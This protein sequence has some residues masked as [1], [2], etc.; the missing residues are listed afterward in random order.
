VADPVAPGLTKN[1]VDA[2]VCAGSTLT[3]TTSSGS[4]GTGTI[5]DQYQYS[6]DNGASWSGWSTS[7]PSFAAVTGTNLVQSRRTASGTGCDTSP[8]NTV[9]WTVVADPVAPGIT[10][11]PADA[12]VCS[13]QTLTVTTS[14]GSGG[15][16][17]TADEY[18]YS[19]DNGG[20]WSS[21]GESVPSFAAVVGI[22]KIQ[23]RRT[24]SGTGCDVSSI[25]EVSWTVVADPI[26][27]G[28]TKNPVDA[29]VCAG[30]TLTVSSIP[31]SGGTGTINDQY[32]YSTDNGS[33][34]SGWSTSVPSFAAVAGT[35]KIQSRRTATGTG[36]DIS[37]VNE[38]S[39]VVNAKQKIT[40]TFN[41]YNVS[42]NILLTGADITVDLYK[43][44]DA[45]HTSLIA[46]DVTDASGYYEL[47]A[48]CPD[49][50]YDIVASSTHTTDGA[51][52]TT[53]AAQANYWGPNPYSIEKVRFHAGDVAGQDLF[54]GGTD[55]GLI[56][57]N[58]VN[59]TDFEAP[60]WTYWRAG[61]AILH[62]PLVAEPEYTEYFP[63]VT[64]AVGSDIN[65]NMYGLATGDFNRSFN[66]SLTKAAS[67]TLLLVY[68]GNRQVGAGQ[69]FDLPVRIVNEAMVGAV[70]LVL[71]FPSDLV[72]VKDVIVDGN[73]GSL[74]WAAKGNELRISWLSPEPLVLAASDELVVI[75][76][77][78][79]PGF[80][81]G[82]SIRVSLAST[83]QNELTDEL[84]NVISDA[85]ISVETIDASALGTGEPDLASTIGFTCYPNPSR[86]FTLFSYSL[87]YE[88]F[89]KL[90]ITNLMG[91]QIE[92]LVNE[93][94]DTGDHY[95]KFDTY[96][97][98]N[99]IYTAT[100]KLKS[101]DNQS[102]MSIK[103][104]NN[105]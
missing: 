41:Y 45:S 4:G 59:G 65:A 95:Y 97:L 61:F 5:N 101:K 70:S 92:T 55:A 27:P 15:A 9:S 56:Q 94:Q 3:V 64:L 43:S 23:S 85:L 78:T 93:S 83:P 11:N 13:G 53:D 24:A 20:T 40:G 32:Q 35:N 19:S 14:A 105:K 39:W 31:G 102:V 36:C 79:K 89:V 90:E 68:D 87:P 42:G 30:V 26:A 28:I 104:I 98:P 48:I 60:D 66:P 16:G 34:W 84:Y 103:L 54:I 12:N 47:N 38:V 46:T 2:S 80:T 63:K 37:S 17:T 75:R 62:N 67:S 74:Q 58:F 44:S 99:G 57:A 73:T 6:T 71:D 25:N 96:S 29:S 72:E 51:I 81:S 76:M 69:E 91:Y 1:P 49:C 52:N 82:K 18:R 33:S 7:V 8:V 21:W 50:D 77:K 88:G 86:N 100:L 10:K 22:S